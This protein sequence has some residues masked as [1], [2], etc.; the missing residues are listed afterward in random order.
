LTEP[1]GSMEPRL[2]NIA[3]RGVVF[4][5]EFV[6]KLIHYYLKFHLQRF[7]VFF[8]EIKTFSKRTAKKISLAFQEVYRQLSS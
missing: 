5:S 3:L 7:K 1:L 4:W 2:K 6:K 8:S